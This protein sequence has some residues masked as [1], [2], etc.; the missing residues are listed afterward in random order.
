MKQIFYEQI[1]HKLSFISKKNSKVCTQLRIFQKEIKSTLN[2][3]L[4]HILGERGLLVRVIISLDAPKSI[5]E[6]GKNLK[7][8]LFWADIFKKPQKP[9]KPQKKPLGWF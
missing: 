2:Q 8:S 9:E 7:N 5:L 4:M 6:T 3:E 1:R